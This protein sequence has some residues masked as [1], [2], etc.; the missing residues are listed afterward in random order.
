MTARLEKLRIGTR[1]RGLGSQDAVTVKSIRWYGDRGDDAVG[2][3]SED[4]GGRLDRKPRDVPEQEGIGHDIESRDR[5]NERFYFIEVKNR[6][7]DDDKITL[8]PTEVLRALDDP[9]RFRLAI[10]RVETGRGQYP[11]HRHGFDLGQPSIAADQLHRL[12]DRSARA[13]R[14]ATMS[15]SP[16]SGGE[17]GTALSAAEPIAPPIREDNP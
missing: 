10:V 7:G 5:T 17:F 15:S 9:G 2:L 12:L 3:V 14:S 16:S 4:G 11:I 6:R 13:R 8:T 1:V